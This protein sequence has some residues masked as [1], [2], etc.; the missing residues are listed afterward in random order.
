MRRDAVQLVRCAKHGNPQLRHTI[1]ADYGIEDHTHPHI[2]LFTHLAYFVHEL[3][4][5]CARDDETTWN[6]TRYQNLVCGPHEDAHMFVDAAFR[7]DWE[8]FWSNVHESYT[9]DLP[10]DIGK[11][12]RRGIE[13]LIFELA[14]L[15]NS[16]LRTLPDC[17]KEWPEDF[18]T[19]YFEMDLG[20]HDH[21]PDEN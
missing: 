3:T 8:I 16:V 21:L 13:E 17:Y 15:G 18:Y 19:T 4:A 11:Y 9:D 2:D 20:E 14:H 12:G 6:N 1:L 5:H 10:E 7:G